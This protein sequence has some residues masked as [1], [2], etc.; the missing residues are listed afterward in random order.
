MRLVRS[1]EPRSFDVVEGPR[2]PSAKGARNVAVGS[3]VT[4]GVRTAIPQSAGSASPPGSMPATGRA[5]RGLLA[6]RGTEDPVDDRVRLV[7]AE[8]ASERP[9]DL[10]ALGSLH[11][12][13]GRAQERLLRPTAG[14]SVQRLRRLNLAGRGTG[15]WRRRARPRAKAR[16]R[17]LQGPGQGPHLLLDVA[18]ALREQAAQL[19]QAARPL[20]DQA[21][22]VAPS[23]R[24][25]TVRLRLGLRADLLRDALGS[26][27]DLLNSRGRLG[28]RPAKLRL[29][30]HGLDP[31]PRNRLR[32]E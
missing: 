26:V 25:I 4:G 6:A 27:D 8:L 19:L 5:S 13:L 24:E 18:G 7:D 14:S 16:D 22:G 3:V 21:I 15:L 20:L 28:D 10:G 9:L 11:R 29:A 2:W 23:L 32:T 12:H 31:S 17:P 1:L 30:P